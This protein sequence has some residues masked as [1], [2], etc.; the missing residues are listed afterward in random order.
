MG[1]ERNN[2]L[3]GAVKAGFVLFNPRSFTYL[4]EAL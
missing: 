4:L 1:R 2:H 3:A